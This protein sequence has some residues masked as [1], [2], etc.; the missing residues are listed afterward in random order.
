MNTPTYRIQVNVMGGDP[1]QWRTL[2]DKFW[3]KNDALAV[4]TRLSQPWE[5]IL[6]FRILKIEVVE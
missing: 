1:N 5:G 2:T 4:K 3:E 6:E